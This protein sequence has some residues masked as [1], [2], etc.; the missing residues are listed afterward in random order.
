MKMKFSGKGELEQLP[1][2][3]L[4]IMKARNKDRF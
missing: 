1:A 4:N 2:A 3:R